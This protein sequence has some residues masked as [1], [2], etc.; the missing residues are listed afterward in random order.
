MTRALVL[1]LAFTLSSALIADTA[2]LQITTFTTS[3]STVT[4]GES[5]SVVMRWRNF[6]PDTAQDVVATI[7][8]N[9]GAFV[10]T[11]AGTEHWPC[12]PTFG[13]DGFA[14]KGFLA[15]GAKAEMIVT[16]LS[17]SEDTGPFFARGHVVSSTPDPQPA[18]NSV[19]T[20]MTL[21]PATA[22]ANLA[23]GP[24]TQEHQVA[25]D[26][27]FS[28]PLM[29]RNAG[30]AVASDVFVSLSF[31][32][33]TRIPVTATGDGWACENPTH[34]PWLVVCRR[35]QL[36]AGATTPV[37]VSVTAPQNTGDYRMYARVAAAGLNDPSLSNTSTVDVRV[38]PATTV[39]TRILVPLPP[40]QTQGAN[41]SFWTTK[42]TALLRSR[43]EMRPFYCEELLPC[44]APLP[45]PILQ[46]FDLVRH[47]LR[48]DGL[49]EFVLVRTKDAS[50]IRLNSRVWDASRQ[51]ETA[52]SEIPIPR[53]D[54]FTKGTIALLGIP[55]AAHY[56][57][58]LRVY[59]LDGRNGARVAIRIYADTE[60]TP[61]ATTTGTLTLHP[62][63]FL[64]TDQLLSTRPASLQLDPLQLA[65]LAGASSMRIEI[66][67]LD[68]GTRIWSFVSVTNN[69]THH[70]TTI[71]AQ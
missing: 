6:G 41:G 27:A 57:H 7:G 5:F 42:T 49:G 40:G 22:N 56:R 10:L 48:G 47:Q 25:P 65:S 13:G 16:M 23:I 21:T 33:G 46:P 17:P 26:A 12:E 64:T 63:A 15:A 34:S 36:T 67:P 14:C 1:L 31:T 43:I 44:P 3:K 32:P 59:D 50:Q 20:P 24:Q 9:S 37:T 39:W 35:P 58:T 11:G 52:G 45:I 70:V 69:D 28:I 38:G 55:V 18:N 19:A 62:S 51:T 61:R 8:E 53:D 68:E 30:P 29:I 66:A 4:T 71:S 54:D 60:T 2:D